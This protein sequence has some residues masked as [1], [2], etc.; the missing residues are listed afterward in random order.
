VAFW[1]SGRE[2]YP[3]SIAAGSGRGNGT[4][5]NNPRN[6]NATH[7]CSQV[8]P[9]RQ[10][11]ERMGLNLSKAMFLSSILEDVIEIVNNGPLLSSRQILG[12]LILPLFCILQLKSHKLFLISFL[13]KLILSS[14]PET[15][16]APPVDSYLAI[17]PGDHCLSGN[18]HTGETRGKVETIEEAPTYIT[19]PHPGRGNGNILFYYPDVHGFYNNAMLL[20]D[21]FADA[22]YTVFGI[23]Y[24]RDV[25]RPFHLTLISSI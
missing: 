24:F 19:S 3:G 23:D 18:L 16:M 22:G 25:T 14:L 15:R 5:T 21:A 13:N 9:S 4:G 17:P 1:A 12:F 2:D 6:V 7:V 8:C 11:I 20:M 10:C